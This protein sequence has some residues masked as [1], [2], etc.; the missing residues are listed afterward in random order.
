MTEAAISPAPQ[1]VSDDDAAHRS[2]VAT[3]PMLFEFSPH[4]VAMSDPDGLSSESIRGLRTH[5]M[6][7]HIREGRRSLTICAP[8]N[9]TGCTFVAT[10]LAVSLASAGV[11]TLLIDANMRDPGIESLI[12]PSRPSIG[13]YDY[14]S[15]R[16]LTVAD[17]IQSDVIANLSIMYAGG[18]AKNAQELLSGNEFKTLIDSCMRDFDLTIVDTPC[19]NLYADARRIATILRYAMIVAARNVSF[20]GDV[21]TLIADLQADRAKVIGTFLNDF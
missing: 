3:E 4:V 11:K 21:K 19:S 8:S 9:E 7:Q 10:N 13:L 2:A 12:R 15:N 5:L 14:L 1:A 17:A 6:A 16:A 20:V 18:V